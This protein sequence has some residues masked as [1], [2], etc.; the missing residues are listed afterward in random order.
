[1]T[2]GLIKC[3]EDDLVALVP[4]VVSKLIKDSFEVVFEKESG[5]NAGYIDQEY[6]NAGA[7]PMAREQI[8]SSTDIIVTVSGIDKSELKLIPGS[9]YLIGKFNTNSDLNTQL[10]LASFKTMSLDKLPRTT[11]AQAMDVL[12]SLASLSG[13]KSVVVGAEHYP[14]YFPMMTTSAGTMPPARVLIL[15]AGVAGLQA[16]AT[17]RRLG[18][19]VEAFDVRSAVKEEV[20]SLGAK[21]IEVEGSTDDAKA[22]GYAVEQSEEYIAKQKELIHQSAAKADVVITTA[23]I[24][25]KKAPVLVEERTI[26]EMKPGSVVVDLAAS[27]GGNCTLTQNEKTVEHK[28][29]K[30]IGNSRLYNSMAKQSS[31]VYSNNLYSFMKFVF[32]EGLENIP[33]DNEIVIKTTITQSKESA[34]TA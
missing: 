27:T 11:F 14:G 3:S 5:L 16:I 28:G 18:A 10:E 23:A 26:N 21:F 20:Q 29:V 24:P 9:S 19:V 12:S 31:L 22:G 2:I 17:A 1:M 34:L 32:K 8:L 15:G 4:K 13:Y 25:G 33:F 7:V 30:V 6:I